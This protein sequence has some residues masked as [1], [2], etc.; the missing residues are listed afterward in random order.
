M[1]GYYQDCEWVTSVVGGREESAAE[2]ELEVA[3]ATQRVVEGETTANYEL[4]K[5]LS[6]YPSLKLDSSNHPLNSLAGLYAQE[7]L[8]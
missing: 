7:V 1:S 8:S 2:I 5:M 6:Q 4:R 3:E